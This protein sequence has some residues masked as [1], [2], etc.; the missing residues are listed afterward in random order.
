MP[1][2]PFK[3]FFQKFRLPISKTEKDIY[4]FLDEHFDEF[5]KEL[6]KILATEKY[7]SEFDRK[8]YTELEKLKPKS[9]KLYEAI[10]HT[11]YFYLRGD[12]FEAHR[13]FKEAMD[14][15]QS[16]LFSSTLRGIVI[17]NQFYRIRRDK[18]E[19]RKDLFHIPL[20][21]RENVR[22]YRY[23]ISGFPSLYLAGSKGGGTGLVLA[24]LE[25]NQP[26]TFYWSEFE[27]VNDAQTIELLDFTWSPFSSATNSQQFDTWRI[28]QE[29]FVPEII[30]KYVMTYPLLAACSLKVENR[31]KP[32]IPEYII[33]QMLL[34][35][36]HKNNKYRGI[37]Y[38]SCTWIQE[39]RKYNAFNVV[40]PPT[41]YTDEHCSQ[42]ANEFKL[43]LPEYV[44][45]SSTNEDKKAL[46]IMLKPNQRKQNEMKFIHE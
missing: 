10:L 18:G 2:K 16:Y 26:D 22:G 32:F 9:Y 31:D 20:N 1:E 41:T 34:S 7:E 44:D 11:L 6:D 24:W 30:S 38:F 33:P 29:E 13:I 35:W 21:Q 43:S 40:L 42:L 45:I 17:L 12:V 14:S 3:T 8:I 46:E 25:S 4:F 23:S 27:L 15:M 39:A 28:R 37:K 5:K 36:V 19:T